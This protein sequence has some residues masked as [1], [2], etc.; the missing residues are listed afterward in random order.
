MED[1]FQKKV[2]VDFEETA[3]SDKMSFGGDDPVYY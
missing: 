2:K 1:G 3:P